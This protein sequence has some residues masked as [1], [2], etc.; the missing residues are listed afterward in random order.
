METHDVITKI[1]EYFDNN[2]DKRMF[3]ND[4]NFD[5]DLKFGQIYEKSLALILQDK[6]IEVKTERDKWKE[7]GNIAIELFNHNKNKPSGLSVTKA[8]YW[9]TILV[10]N[11]KLYSI[12][13]LPVDY[14]KRRVKEIVK[15]GGGKIVNGGDFNASELALI[16]IKEIFGC[17]Q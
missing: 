11:F 10:H 6:Q 9:A 3:N 2:L 4:S 5:I 1:Q 17:T 7:T 15:S 16:P 14:L 13:I 8:S 12:H